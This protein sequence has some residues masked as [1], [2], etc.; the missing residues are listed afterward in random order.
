VSASYCR[1]YVTI[2]LSNSFLLEL[3]AMNASVRLGDVSSPNATVEL[4]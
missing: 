4:R 3:I 2:V 1:P